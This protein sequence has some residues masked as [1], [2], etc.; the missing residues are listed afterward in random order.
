MRVCVYVCM[1]AYVCVYILLCM[2]LW[3]CMSTNTRKQAELLK[4]KHA[5]EL[6]VQVLRRAGGEKEG[7]KGVGGVER[8]LRVVKV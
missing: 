7:E 2:Q 4:E 6:E 5:H 1:C 8:G 3:Y